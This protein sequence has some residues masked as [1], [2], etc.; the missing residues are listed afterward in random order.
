MKYYK[1]YTNNGVLECYVKTEY[2]VTP[3]ELC[4]KI[5]CPNYVAVPITKQCFEEFMYNKYNDYDLKNFKEL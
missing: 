4:E 2:D 3:E 1:I 5:G